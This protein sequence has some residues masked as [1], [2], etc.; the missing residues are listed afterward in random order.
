MRNLILIYFI[1]LCAFVDAQN[2]VQDSIIRKSYQISK[3]AIAPKIDGFLNDAVWENLP[4]ATN[5]V[6]R[7]PKNGNPAPDSLR[8]EVKLLYDNLGIYVG[9]MMYDDRPD[10]I[11]KEM[12]E[13]DDL[14]NDDFFFITLNG[15]NDKQQSYVFIVTAAGVQ[16]DEKIDDNGDDFSWNAVWESS[17]QIVEN[18]WSAE[19]FIPFRELRFPDKKV[20]DW[21]L[22][23]ER[24]VR[25]IRTRYSWNHI[26]NQ[27]NSF[28]LFDGILSGIEN[29]KPPTRLSF[30]PYASAYINQY[31]GENTTNLNGGMDIKYGINEAFTLDMTL[32]PDFGQA[33][34]DEK[35]LNLGPFE[36]QFDEQRPFFNEGIDLFNKGNLFY[37]RRIGDRPSK[38]PAISE[39]EVVKN[40]PSKVK[41]LN[42]SKISGRTKKGLGIGV[43]HA[44]TAKTDVE[45]VDTITGNK[46]NEIVE[47][48][49]NYNIIALNQRFRGNSSI[50]LVNTH[51]LRNSDFRNSNVTGAYWDIRNKNNNYYYYGGIEGSWLYGNQQK[52]GS[53]IIYGANKISGKNRYGVSSVVRSKNYDINDLGFTGQTNYQAYYGFYEYLLLQP[54]GIFNNYSLALNINYSRRLKPDLFQDFSVNLS[55]RFTTKKFFSFGGGF[56]F[57]PFET[58]DIYEPRSG[59]MYL[60]YPAIYNHFGWISTDY[61]KRFALDFNYNMSKMNAKNRNSLF[62]ILQPRLRVSDRW[63]LI[64]GASFNIR[65]ADV[66]F[67]EKFND[68]VIMGQRNQTTVITELNSQYNFNPDLAVNLSLRHYTSAVD[69]T[70]FYSLSPVGDLLPTTYI[71]Q[72]DNTYNSWNLDIRCSWWFAPGSQLTLLYRNAIDDFQE[73]HVQDYPKNIARISDIPKVNNLSLRLVYFLDYNRFL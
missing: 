39:N 58:N 6:E 55:S 60:K 25:R 27:K 65:E 34:Y 47:P 37:T 12:T 17:V 20:Q 59:N 52:F 45:I 7:Q 62:V 71:E 33:A 11:L 14:G 67:V 30:Y 23:F 4:I 73:M 41:L 21:G 70:N 57:Y 68:E 66:G 5:F 63:K 1:F 64:A 10:R 2:V 48:L 43:F 18:G 49:A 46:R 32:I 19:M 24:E 8:T 61:R 50:S 42:A 15:Y 54:K 31:D 40:Y 9:A 22:N 35:I 13:R 44:I 38:Y 51:V 72:R 3:T 36:Q 29:I 53:E 69:Y 16:L 56:E 28:T 26:D